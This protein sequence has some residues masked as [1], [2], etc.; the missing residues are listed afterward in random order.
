MT[1]SNKLVDLQQFYDMLD[2]NDPDFEN[3]KKK[4]EAMEALF[5][6]WST[7]TDDQKSS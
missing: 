6:K 7:A 3:D 4:I 1:D 2:P 5:K